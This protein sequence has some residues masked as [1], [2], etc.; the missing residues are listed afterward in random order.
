M[1]KIR[2]VDGVNY[3]SIDFV[4]MQYLLVSCCVDV[5]CCLG[6]CCEVQSPKRPTQIST[7]FAISKT[8]GA[9]KRNDCCNVVTG[10]WSVDS[11]EYSR[12]QVK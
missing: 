10:M 8:F 4:A 12:P 2:R 7:A 5:G 9:G 11:R 3:D 6:G 1:N